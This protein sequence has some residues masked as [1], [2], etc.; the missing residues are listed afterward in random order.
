MKR[1]KAIFFD[2]DGTAVLSRTASPE[3]A[4]AA[5]RPLLKTGTA[6]VIISGTTYE[7][8]AGGRLHEFFSPQELDNLF[9]GLG[10]G[11]FDYAFDAGQPKPICNRTPDAESL[12][13]LHRLCFSL[14][15]ELMERYGLNTDIVFTRPNYCKIDLLPDVNRGSKLF[16]QA[17]EI[18]LLRSALA[19]HGIQNGIHGLFSL[20]E[21]LA[22]RAG[23][24]VKPTT[25]A[26]YLEVGFTTKSD[27]TDGVL[28]YLEK[29]RSIEAADCAFFGDEYVG[30][31]QGL[32]G[33]DAYMLTEKTENGDFF[34]VSETPGARPACVQVIGG[35][36]ERFLSVLH[37]QESL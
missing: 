18:E 22:K 3:A 37:E 31:A 23:L 20:T 15:M 24:I 21:E 19:A 13:K 30:V 34:D 10:R 6:L 4:V 25:D 9:L 2:W 29:T 36:V 5:M 16:L 7:N 17:S 32:Y 8:I 1:Y 33:S 14:H 27:N 12:L 28:S 35:G 11:A 26:K